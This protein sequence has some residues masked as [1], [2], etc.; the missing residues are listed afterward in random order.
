LILE[1]LILLLYLMARDSYG[2]VTE[3]SKAS[4]HRLADARALFK[5]KRWRAT[6]Y[7]AGYVI[8]CLLKAKLMRIFACRHLREVEEELHDRGL[9]AAEDFAGIQR[10]GKS[11]R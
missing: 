8:E 4:K 9:V 6:M 1:T 2:G 3:Q 10:F 11:F 7:I 5:E